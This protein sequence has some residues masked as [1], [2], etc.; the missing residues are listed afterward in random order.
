MC[1]NLCLNSISELTL[2]YSV[3]CLNTI[4]A[5]KPRG[6][7]NFGDYKNY[8]EILQQR[9]KK[10]EAMNQAP[11]DPQAL[12]RATPLEAVFVAEF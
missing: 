4:K 3:F 11:S 2:L 5:W 12:R 8:I 7:F 6:F 10:L 1:F 9:I